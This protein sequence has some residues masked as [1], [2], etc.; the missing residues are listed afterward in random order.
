[1]VN[2]DLFY[3]GGDQLQYKESILSSV[4]SLVPASLTQATHN[5]ARTL[6]HAIVNGCYPVPTVD[7]DMK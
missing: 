6:P 2:I 3:T 1:M 7:D 4:M 5:W